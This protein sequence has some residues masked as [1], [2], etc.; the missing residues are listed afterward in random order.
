MYASP[1]QYARAASWVDAV[2]Q[3]AAGGEEARVI[4]GGQSLAPMMMLRMAEPS[5]LVDVNGAAPRTIA[6]EN[7]T[8]VLSALVRHA[9]LEAS[10]DVRAAFP[11]LAEAAGWI[12]NVRVR[13]RGTIGGSL[14]HADP[15]AEYPCVALAAGAAITALGPGGERSIPAAEFFVSHF[16]TALEPGEL[17]TRVAVPALRP[18]EGCAFAEL[19][20]RPGDFATVEVCAFVA[21]GEDGRC[22]GARLALGA[23]A[24]RPLDLSDAL[25]ALSGEEPER[26]AA[27]AAR[28]AAALAEIG[29]SGHGSEGYR[30]ELVAVLG[31]RALLAA[32]ARARGEEPAW[33]G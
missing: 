7:G 5:L 20:R 26:A 9:E 25:Q 4:A 13:H 1:F 15:S 12:G 28:A 17:V 30:R 14:A 27:E 31:R 10:D 24:D 11:A 29:E 2:E 6:R 8:L 33:T 3:V 19:S 21:L 18:R 32:A 22:R 23:T 16:T